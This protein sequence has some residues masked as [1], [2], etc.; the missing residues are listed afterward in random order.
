VTFFGSSR[1]DRLFEDGEQALDT[2]DTRRAIEVFEEVIL[3]DDRNVAAWF[4]L[5]LAYKLE[6]DWPNSARCNRRAAEF[7]RSNQEASWNLGVAATALRD[8]PT[9]RWAWQ[10][11]GLDPGAGDGPPEMSLGPTPIRLEPGEVVWAERIDPCRG[12]ITNVP[13]PDSGHRWR[14]VVLHDVVP[15]GEREAWGKT[16]HVFD[17]LVR[18][19]AGEYPTLESEVVAPSEA[20]S[21]ALEDEATARGVAAEDWTASVRWLC[22]T[23]SLGSAHEHEARAGSPVWLPTRRFG[24]AGPE[25][26]IREM[27][28]AWSASAG[29]SHGPLHDAGASG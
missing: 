2:G 7:D 15:A 9:A 19:D 6:R 23:C 25:P 29:R 20:D 27:L 21:S 24:F 17:E 1:T 16:W 4:N 11:I 5:G 14:D 8:W 10:N 22:A 3:L 26:A 13:L 28:E 12:R 18:M